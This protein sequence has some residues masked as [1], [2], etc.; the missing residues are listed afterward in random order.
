LLG[1]NGESSAL[2]LLDKIKE[3]MATHPMPIN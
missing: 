1:L 3:D 2:Q